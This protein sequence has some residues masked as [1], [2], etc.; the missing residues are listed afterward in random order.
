[1]EAW[2]VSL[3][4][5]R[6]KTVYRGCM[7]A[8]TVS[9]TFDPSQTVVWKK[10]RNSKVFAKTHEDYLAAQTQVHWK[11]GYSYMAFSLNVSVLF[12]IK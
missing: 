8:W 4:F 7:E 12:H 1:M 10:F 2:T 11:S 9:L 6:L 3:T 5:D